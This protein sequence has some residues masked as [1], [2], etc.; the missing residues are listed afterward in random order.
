MRFYVITTGIVFAAFVVAHV[1]RVAVEGT[2]LAARPEF[3]LIT[4]G[5]AGLSIWAWRLLRRAGPA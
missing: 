1:W 4:L 5:L 3:V 2:Q